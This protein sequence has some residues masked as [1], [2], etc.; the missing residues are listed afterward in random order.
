VEL[1]DA[2]GNVLACKELIDS[3]QHCDGNCWP[4]TLRQALAFP[5]EATKLVIFE[6]KHSIYEEA[7]GAPPKV[8]VRGKYDDKK[9][10]VDL[11][12]TSSEEKSVW[13]LLQ[14]LDIDGSWRG[15]GPRTEHR[16]ARVPARLIGRGG[17][18][19][20]RVLASA[21]IATGVGKC[22]VELPTPRG[23]TQIVLLNAGDG[24]VPDVLRVAVVDSSGR[25]VVRPDVRWYDAHGREV[26]RGRSI[27]LTALGSGEHVLRAV[28]LHTSEPAVAMSYV[29]RRAN[30]RNQLVSA[31]SDRPPARAAHAHDPK[32]GEPRHKA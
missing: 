28:A 6:G 23:E 2:E 4:K 18:V 16:S 25:S 8:E 32:T 3:C 14:W 13:Y 11:H 12:W 17:N 10:E 5:K 22:S 27:D 19:R 21:A 7:I 20:F 24:G 15:V 29:V 1:S 30:A 31:A 26:A 9:Q